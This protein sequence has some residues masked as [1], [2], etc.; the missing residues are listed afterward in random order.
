MDE[1]WRVLRDPRVSTTLVFAVLAVA[2]FA[3]VGLAWRGAAATLF[4]VLQLPWVVSGA[5]GG[6]ALLGL[7][8]AGLMTHLD[9]TEAAAE[10]AALA[11]LQRDVL[12]MLSVAT[13]RAAD[14]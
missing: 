5:F 3:L 8:L 2:G 4:V 13:Q 11:D 14:R 9:R 1:I 6:I 10:R 12:R 7:A